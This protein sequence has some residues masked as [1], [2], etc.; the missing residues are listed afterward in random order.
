MESFLKGRILQD[1]DQFE[2]AIKY[3]DTVFSINPQFQNSLYNKGVF[4]SIFSRLLNISTRLWPSVV[5]ILMSN[6]SKVHQNIFLK[7]NAYQIQVIDLNNKKIKCCDI[8]QPLTCSCHIHQRYVQINLLK[9]YYQVNRVN[10]KRR[11]NA[12]KTL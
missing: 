11:F 6:I 8:A 2:Q 1:T 4:K 5:K 3:Y 7:V 12:L 10:M 9:V